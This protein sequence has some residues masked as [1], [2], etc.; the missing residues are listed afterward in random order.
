MENLT[1]RNFLV[2]ENASLDVKK[3][4]VIIGSQGTGKSVLAKLLYCFKSIENHL[5]SFLSQ[6]G[7]ESLEDFRQ[8]FK[9]RFLS[10]FPSY[11][12]EN[13]KFKITYSLDL[14]K[15]ELE[16]NAG[17]VNFSLSE[18]FIE[19][20]YFIKSKIRK[21]ID[22]LN[23]TREKNED[24]L[25]LDLPTHLIFRSEIKKVI[26][27]SNFNIFLK[28][29]NF[30]PASRSFFSM[31]YENIFSIL[32]SKNNLD[33]FLIEFGHMYEVYKSIYFRRQEKLHNFFPINIVNE[34][35]CGDIQQIDNKYFLI[36]DTKKTD[37]VNASSGQQEAFPMLIFLAVIA[38][39]EGENSIFIEEPEAHLFPISQAQIV[40]ILSFMYKKQNNFFITTHSPY[41]LS[42]LNNYLYAQDL[43][44]RGLL[45]L[46]D[47]NKILPSTSPI[48]INNI[49]A[50]KIENGILTSIVDEEFSIIDSDELDK[51]SSHAS[52]IYNQLLEFETED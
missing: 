43:I 42:E 5:I 13:Q 1:V 14:Y 45:S 22:T 31:F 21:L 11:A 12:W 6:E 26:N 29:S 49:S 52:D 35:L 25:N 28:G 48:D 30:I 40:K 36:N 50:Y 38:Y 51:A 23:N 41:I 34:I 8:D 20:F 32:T 9:K 19:E 18:N 17:A 27:D 24:D 39:F 3:F 47:F 44:K 33:P 37:L 2:I 46:E 4:N 7:P 16:N 10:I 15:F